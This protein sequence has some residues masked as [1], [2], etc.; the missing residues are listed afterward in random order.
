MKANLNIHS[1]YSDGTLWSEE[2]LY[3]A[4]KISIILMA[5]TDLAN[6]S[7]Y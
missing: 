3:S 2:I 7:D 5:L 1:R 6:L 4:K